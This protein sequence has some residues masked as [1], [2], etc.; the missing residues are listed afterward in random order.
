M[1]PTAPPKLASLPREAAGPIFQDV[2]HWSAWML[3]K[4]VT[5]ADALEKTP[6][7]CATDRNSVS[8]RLIAS[9]RILVQ[10]KPHP[11]W[12]LSHAP[13]SFAP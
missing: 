12:V 8:P 1:R 10:T 6:P 2:I 13:N 3:D 5:L 11:L 4:L 9:S 7:D